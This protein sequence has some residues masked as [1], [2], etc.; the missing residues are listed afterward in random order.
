MRRLEPLLRGADQLEWNPKIKYADATKLKFKPGTFL[1]IYSSHLLEHLNFYDAQTLVNKCYSILAPGGI[2]R[3][4]LPD[5]DY[6]VDRYVKDRLKNPVDAYLDYEESLLSWPL[7]KRSFKGRLIAGIFGRLHVHKWH[8]TIA[9]VK[10]MLETTGFQNIESCSF[11]EGHF[12]MMSLVENRPESTFYV[13]AIKSSQ[14]LK[15]FRE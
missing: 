11:R 3:L 5:Y 13:E 4:A 1:G 15:S 8:P 12:P 2:L 6:F 10:V 7:E 14:L 9:I